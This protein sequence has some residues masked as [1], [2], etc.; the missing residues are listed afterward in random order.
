MYMTTAAI[1]TLYEN[2]WEDRFGDADDVVREMAALAAA[3]PLVHAGLLTP[4]AAADAGQSELERYVDGP[5]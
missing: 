5:G 1:Y 2:T 4:D 3:T